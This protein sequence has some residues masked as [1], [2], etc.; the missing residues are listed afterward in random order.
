D[1][2]QLVCDQALPLERADSEL[3]GAKHD[4]AADSVGTSPYPPRRGRRFII[5]MHPHT[6]EVVPELRLEERAQ[7]ARQACPLVIGRTH[8][9]SRVLA[10]LQTLRRGGH[11]IA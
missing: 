5:D 11:R 8:G 6:A 7:L 4:V 3:A 9:A 10:S 1:V 2:G